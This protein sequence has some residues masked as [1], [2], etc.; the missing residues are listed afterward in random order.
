MEV[1]DTE[2]CYKCKK[3]KESDKH[4]CCSK[5]REY[6]KA[7]FYRNRERMNEQRKLNHEKNK[8]QDRAYWQEYKQNNRDKISERK[9]HYRESNKEKLKEA[10]QEYM[11]KI[12]HCPLCNYDIKLY[13]KAQHEKSQTHQNNLKQKSETKEE[14]K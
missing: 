3:E 7:Y 12:Y 14:E 13:K 2:R 8:E 11:K 10:R 9:K 6:L 1:V 5:C 4:K